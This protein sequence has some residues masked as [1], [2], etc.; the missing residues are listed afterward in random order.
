MTTD[1]VQLR[2]RA[3]IA[4]EYLEDTIAMYHSVGYEAPDHVYKTLESLDRIEPCLYRSNN[5]GQWQLLL[6]GG[7]LLASIVSGV[8]AI[9]ERASADKAQAAVE[10][11]KMSMIERGILTEDSLNQAKDTIGGT[12]DKIRGILLIATTIVAIISISNLLKKH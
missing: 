7:M 6:G 11:Q 5:F 8:V 9:F 1:M 4:R 10:L 3:K 12:L 2:Q